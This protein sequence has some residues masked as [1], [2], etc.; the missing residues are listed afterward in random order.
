MFHWR[1]AILIATAAAVMACGGASDGSVT[2]PTVNPGT[3]NPSSSANLI[4]V[5]D[6]SFSPGTVTVSAGTTVTWQWTPCSGSGGY[7]GYGACVAHNVT[8][9]DGT[10]IASPVQ[11]SGSFNRTFS[12]P[13]TYKYHCVIHGSAM[14][15]TIVVK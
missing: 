9:D 12:T 7:G 3:S 15:G 2:T 11:D 1:G 5:A 6:N 4:G 14:S 8:F 13:G 10:N